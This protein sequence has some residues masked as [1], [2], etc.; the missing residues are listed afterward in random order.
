MRLAVGGDVLLELRQL[1]EVRDLP[2]RELQRGGLLRLFLFRFR[3]LFSFHCMFSFR[4]LFGLL[5]R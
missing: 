4:L 5:V 3:F 2:L 1:R